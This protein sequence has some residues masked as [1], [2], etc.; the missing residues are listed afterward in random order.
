MDDQT[1]PPLP[2]HSWPSDAPVPIDGQHTHPLG[3]PYIIEDELPCQ[4]CGYILKGLQSDGRCP[5]C[6]TPIGRS[7]HGNYLRFANPHYVRKLARGVALMLWGLLAWVIGAFGAGLLAFVGIPAIGG[8]VALLVGLTYLAGAWLAT[9]PNPSSLDEGWQVS[10][11]R[12]VRVALAISLLGS[13][14]SYVAQL[15]A[16]GAPASVAAT[17]AV[18]SS[19]TSLAWI[20]GAVATMI[21][22]RQLAF[23]IPDHSIAS[24]TRVVAWGM[25]L[26]M[27]AMT[28]IGLGMLLF[29]AVTGGGGSVGI[30]AAVMGGASCFLGLGALVFGIWWII[31]LLRYRRVLLEQ[32]RMAEASWY[33]EAPDAPRPDDVGRELT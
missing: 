19:V 15:F 14:V 31:L 11:R 25:G 18:F 29:H 9:T 30:S 23:L 28:L 26:S 33:A 21:Y 20:V 12:V 1:H 3:E 13:V 5:E 4:G 7:L 6:A 10:A 2:P 16:G 27:G 8:L 22:F 24:Q 17:L 32:A